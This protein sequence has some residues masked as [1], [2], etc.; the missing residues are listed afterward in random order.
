MRASVRLL[1]AALLAFSASGAAALQLVTEDDPPHNMLR[2]GKVVGIS[3]EKLQEAFR[4]AGVSQQIELMPWARAYRSAL[5]QSDYC[6]FSAARTPA[7]E[8]LFK[9]IGPVGT[10]EWV[11]YTRAG[12]HKPAR[13][14][15]L[16]GKIIGGYV[17]DV[18]SLWLSEHGFRVDAATSD[19][20][21][22]R[23]LQAGHIDYWASTRPRGTALLAQEG[24]AKEIVP[25]LTFGHTDLY[26]ACHTSTPDKVVHEVNHALR[27]MQEDGTAEKIEA[28]YARWPGE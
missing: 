12:W 2:N 21:N 19:A 11:L 9:W 7:R 27:R 10:T 17:Q 23:K 1:A 20:I 5:T 6:V 22:P 8:A 4:R 13:L 24:L 28:R 25:V 14:E 3:T 15:D 18:I 16:R 26:L